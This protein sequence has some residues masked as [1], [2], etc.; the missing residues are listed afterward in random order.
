[1]IDFLKNRDAL[2][3]ELDVYYSACPYD[4]AVQNRR[5]STAGMMQRPARR[6]TR[7]KRW[8]T[9]AQRSYALY[10]YLTIRRFI[11]RYA[12]V[13]SGIPAKMDFHQDPDWKDGICVSILRSM[14]RL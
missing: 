3:D 7:E 12:P 8:F 10:R 2:K 5:S 13:G 14:R 11:M 4:I 9:V 1:M 6:S